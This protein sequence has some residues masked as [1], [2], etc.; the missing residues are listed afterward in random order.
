MDRFIAKVKKIQESDISTVIAVSEGVKLPDGR[1]VCELGEGATSTDAFGHKNMTGTARVLA[2]EVQKQLGV[3]ARPV[4]LSI[5]QRCAGHLT[6]RIDI[7]EAH[8]VGGAAV[9]A[10]VKGES[11]RTVILRRISNNPYQIETALAPSSELANFEKKVPLEWINEDHTKMLQPFF[12]Y[13]SPLIQGEF[14]PFY[15]NGLPYH[16][17]SIKGK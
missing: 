9:I 1:Y 17:S 6:S 10:A 12:D 16:L 13:A 5:L 2:N 14:E 15:V 4:E 7:E 11:G 8:T 3:R